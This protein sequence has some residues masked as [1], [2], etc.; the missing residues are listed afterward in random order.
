MTTTTTATPRAISDKT[1]R[2]IC[3]LTKVH[4]VEDE[5]GHRLRV[6][7]HA[8]KLSQDQASKAIEM[9]RALPER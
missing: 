7:A 5:L 8:G 6:L 4:A 2:Y 9:L 3:V 1:V